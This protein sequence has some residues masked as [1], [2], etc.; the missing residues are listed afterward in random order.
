MGPKV[1]ANLSSPVSSRIKY[2]IVVT[3]QPVRRVDIVYSLSI[4]LYVCF[5][6]PPSYGFPS[7]SLLYSIHVNPERSFRG[8]NDGPSS[9]ASQALEGGSGGPPRKLKQKP[10][11]QM[12]Q[13]ELFLSYIC[14]YN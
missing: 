5:D 1:S 10:V 2:N 8:T 6:V 13:S 14:Q 11:L 3:I 4:A 7:I 12:V 9:E